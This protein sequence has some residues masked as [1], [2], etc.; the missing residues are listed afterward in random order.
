MNGRWVKV[1]THLYDGDANL[2]SMLN[3]AC[4]GVNAHRKSFPGMV[5]IINQVIGNM[6][7]MPPGS[8]LDIN[9][10]TLRLALDINGACCSL[11][12]SSNL[13]NGASR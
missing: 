3:S 12:A 9:N 8:E 4:E 11:M 6:S 5:S 1:R 13:S 7:S 10:V 2:S